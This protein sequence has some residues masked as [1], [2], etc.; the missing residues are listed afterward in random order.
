MRRQAKSY[1]PFAFLG[2]IAWIAVTIGDTFGTIITIFAVMVWACAA[3]MIV[4]M[5]LFRGVK[6]TLF[7]DDAVPETVYVDEDGVLGSQRDPVIVDRVVPEGVTAV[8]TP[9]AID[10]T[11]PPATDGTVAITETAAHPPEPPRPGTAMVTTN[12]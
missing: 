3:L 11:S 9:V 5:L 6:F 12:Q 7:A 4:Y 1:L 8:A 2:L 10:G